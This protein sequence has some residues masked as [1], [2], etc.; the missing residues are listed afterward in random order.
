MM[1]RIITETKPELSTI[2][3]KYFSGFTMLFGRGYSNGKS[4]ACTV[5]EIDTVDGEP[6][7]KARIQSI[8]SEIKLTHKQTSVLVQTF[9]T[10][11]GALR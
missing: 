9:P 6:N 3:S 1:Y 7:P 10:C 8:V 2:V 4:E 11:S 5:I